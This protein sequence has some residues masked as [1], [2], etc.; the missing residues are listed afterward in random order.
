[1]LIQLF[2]SELLRAIAYLVA[3]EAAGEA[4]VVDAPYGVTA[5]IAAFLQA[6]G[7]R[8]CSVVN[9][10]G[11]FDHIADNAALVAATGAE[12]ACHRNEI[13]RLTMP[14]TLGF[15]LPFSLQPSQ[16]TRP[17][18]EGDVLAAGSLRLTVLHTP[19]HTPG[20]ICLYAADAGLLFTGDTLFAGTYGR[21][22]LPGGDEATMF[23]TLTRLSSLPAETK[24]FPGHGEDSTIGAEQPW[25]ERVR[26]LARYSNDAS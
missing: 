2:E 4:I 23:A 9:T 15:P 12:L 18:Q 6:Q 20:S 5:E 21:T 7:W 19:G 11:H 22:D 8:L 1:V 13:A 3:D 16:P 24:F 26:M 17:L 25:L 14:E 10:H